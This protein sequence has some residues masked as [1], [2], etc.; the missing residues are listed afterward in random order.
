MLLES[1]TWVF[2]CILFS[3]WWR[4]TQSRHSTNI[5]WMSECTLERE[6]FSGPVF[7]S[8]EPVCRPNSAWVWTSIQKHQSPHFPS[9][10]CGQASQGSYSPTTVFSR[11]L[12]TVIFSPSPGSKA[13][14][15]W[16]REA[17]QG[18]AGCS[19]SSSFPLPLGPTR[20]PELP[21]F[22]SWRAVLQQEFFSANELN[23]L[24]LYLR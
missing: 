11:Q 6:V 14:M 5:D 3:E 17:S 18:P 9:W 2:L 1:R 7:T 8:A 22:T 23:D 13:S 24:V 4:M 20:R 21:T 12:P 15:K 19:S 16:K 10:S